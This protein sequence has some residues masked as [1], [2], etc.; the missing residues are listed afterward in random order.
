MFLLSIVQRKKSQKIALLVHG[1]NSS[2]CDTVENFKVVGKLQD[3]SILSTEM[4]DLCA[5]L[6]IY[7]V[8]K[9]RL[10]Q[11][12]TKKLWDEEEANVAEMPAEG[13][14]KN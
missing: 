6:P 10:S 1:Y 7:R 5:N 12:D 4:A 2:L 11:D 14:E 3:Q 9:G 13:E 8:T